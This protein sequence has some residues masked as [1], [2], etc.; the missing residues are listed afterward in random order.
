LEKQ[1]TTLRELIRR[2]LALRAQEGVKVRQPLAAAYVPD[3]DEEM[4]EILKEELNVKS[5]GRYH[6]HSSGYELNKN[7]ELTFVERYTEWL[8]VRDNPSEW[9]PDCHCSETSIDNWSVSGM[10]MLDFKITPELKKE[11]LMREVVRVVQAARKSAGLNVDDRIKLNL[12]TDS[13]ELKEA[14]D[15]FKNEI[16]VEVLAEA[17]SEAKLKYVEEVKVE[18]SELSLSLEKL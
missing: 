1:M 14:I 13:Q 4:Q 18:G 10:M 16:A 12:S 7:K 15:K 2:G 11:G 5:L 6:M 9:R 17:W 8:K 3:M